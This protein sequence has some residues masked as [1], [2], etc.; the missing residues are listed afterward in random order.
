MPSPVRLGMAGV[1]TLLEG[2]APLIV[3]IDVEGHEETVIEALMAS[4]HRARIAA[5]FYEIDERWVDAPA[6]EARLRAAC[7]ARFIRFGVGRHYDILAE[8]PKI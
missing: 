1:D 2:T 8:L 4:A 5:I 3:K 6:I 7:F